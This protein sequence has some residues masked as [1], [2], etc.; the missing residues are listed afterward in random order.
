MK[1][2]SDGRSHLLEGIVRIRDK[3]AWYPLYAWDAKEC[4]GH[5]GY[6]LVSIG[7]VKRVVVKYGEIRLGIHGMRNSRGG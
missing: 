4:I 2:S 1:F 6:A 5:F 3:K 7:Y